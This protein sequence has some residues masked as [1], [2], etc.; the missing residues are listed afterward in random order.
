VPLIF[1]VAGG[2][3]G[4]GSGHLPVIVSELLS[5]IGS[6]RARVIPVL[7]TGA[8]MDKVETGNDEKR[9]DAWARAI[10]AQRELD[11]LPSGRLA[12][13]FII[14]A[15]PQ[16]LQ[17]PGIAEGIL[18]STSLALATLVRHSNFAQEQIV[19]WTGADVAGAGPD[20][21]HSTFGAAELAFPAERF[22]DWLGKVL[23]T[24]AWERIATRTSDGTQGGIQGATKILQGMT[25]GVMA[26]Q[27]ARTAPGRSSAAA[28]L[29]E[30]AVESIA[31]RRRGALLRERLVPGVPIRAAVCYEL[32]VDAQCLART[33]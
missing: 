30:D 29:S 33:T 5:I 25:F 20:E 23:A 3:G 28:H 8:Y 27:V 26:D 16:V 22:S 14:G 12:Q 19:N 13:K 18:A 17:R 11:L 1:V 7:L 24:E 10:A 4:V 31:R 15:G 6:T 32:G 9:R 2:G 21:L